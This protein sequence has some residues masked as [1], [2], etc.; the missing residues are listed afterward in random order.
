MLVFSLDDFI[1]RSPAEIARMLRSRK[2][3]Y[4]TLALGAI[5]AQM[6]E[7]HTHQS[8]HILIGGRFPAGASSNLTWRA[9]DGEVYVM[10]A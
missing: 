4:A 2:R 10:S 5:V 8:G 1:N 6:R 7:R 9:P 3:C